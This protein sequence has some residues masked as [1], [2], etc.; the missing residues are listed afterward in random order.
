[1]K[2]PA[3]AAALGVTLGILAF[4][5]YAAEAADPAKAPLSQPLPM[6]SLEEQ[7][8]RL[9]AQ[10]G[11]PNAQYDLAVSLITPIPP[12]SGPIKEGA[13]AAELLEKSALQ[14]NID[15]AF[16]LGHIYQYGTGVSKDVGQ[17][18][19]WLTK[20]ADGGHVS[21][22]V[23]LGVMYRVGDGVMKN[24]VKARDYY[25]KAAEKGNNNARTSLA[26]MYMEGDGVHKDGGMAQTWLKRAVKDG[27]APA[28]LAIGRLYSAKDLNLVNGP[29]AIYWTHQA[30]AHGHAPAIYALGLLY[31]DGVGEV[32]PDA[33][34]AYLWL[35]LAYELSSQV[36]GNAKEKPYWMGNAERVLTPD[37]KKKADAEFDTWLKKGPPAPPAKEPQ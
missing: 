36:R 9:A 28:M 3:I 34:N 25:A 11:D 14:G 8:L 32:K 19:G 10:K 2:K 31:R 17:S 21:A 37:Q 26:V 23:T 27:H 1:M 4:A 15:A 5:P 7:A 6:Q 16:L 35:R 20:A 13:E 24:R 30:I 22:M 33:Y 18:L 29:K 12:H